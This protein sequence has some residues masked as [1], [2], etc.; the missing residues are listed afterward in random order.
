[1]GRLDCIASYSYR[2]IIMRESGQAIAEKFLDAAKKHGATAA[3]VML[4]QSQDSTAQCRVGKVDIVN[5]A[6]SV[7]IGLRALV[8]QRV[9]LVSTSDITDE[10]ID[11]MAATAVE[12]AKV[13][14]EDPQAGLLE[15]QQIKQQELDLVDHSSVDFAKLTDMAMAADQAGNSVKGVKSAEDCSATAAKSR[16][17]LL[18]TN[19]LAH[20]YESTSFSIVARMVAA[21]DSGMETDYMYS[22]ATHVDDLLPAAEVGQMAGEYAAKRLSAGPSPTG[23]VPVVLSQ[24][25]ARGLLQSFAAAISG[26]SV[27]KKLS[28]MKDSMDQKVFNEN[29][30]IVDDPFKKRGLRSKLVDVE[31]IVPQKQNIVKNGRLQSWLLDSKSAKKLQLPSTGHAHRGVGSHASPA[32]T[33]LTLLPGESSPTDLMSDIKSGVYITSLMGHGINMVS[34]DYSRG[35]AGFLIENGQLTRPFSEGTIAGNLRDMF[36][37]STPANDLCRHEG[38]DVPTVRIDGMT[39]AGRV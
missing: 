1:M 21:D 9:S 15:P 10:S 12:M 26:D 24:R 31:G 8:G 13:M 5:S 4:T 6:N 36:L 20:N 25:V 33:N 28:F 38:I 34:G 18:N 3:D 2:E 7:R 39:V 32:P 27:V 14:P 11:H 23:Q 37:H 22:V 16:T 17:I 30:T 35:A 19:G 29:I